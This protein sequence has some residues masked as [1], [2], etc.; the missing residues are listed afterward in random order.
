MTS[1]KNKAG[2]IILNKKSHTSVKMIKVTYY[3]VLKKVKT[4]ETIIS[5]LQNSYFTNI[6][7][8]LICPNNVPLLNFDLDN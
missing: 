1:F 8:T 3:V 2:V 7:P 4:M 6:L 5:K